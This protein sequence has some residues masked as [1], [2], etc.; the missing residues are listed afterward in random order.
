[1]IRGLR[2]KIYDREDINFKSSPVIFDDENNYVNIS[3]RQIQASNFATK[4]LS[5]IIVRYDK[6]VLKK[7]LGF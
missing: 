5:D 4:E 7:Q 1:M 3:C 6:K 2:S